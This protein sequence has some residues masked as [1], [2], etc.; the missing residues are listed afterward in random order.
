VSRAWLIVPVLGIAAIVTIAALFFYEVH[1][2]G[3]YPWYGW[4][5]FPFPFFPLI[6]IP[7]IFLAFFVFRG[8][9]W[10]EGWCGL[11]GAGWHSTQY[12]DPAYEILKERFARGEITK[13]QF[14][15]MTK[16]L[17]AH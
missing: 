2:A 12:S 3:V 17:E 10:G 6:F 16:D 14:E 1:P 4:W 15:Q 9:F 13:D 7:V 5:W 8:I 11:G